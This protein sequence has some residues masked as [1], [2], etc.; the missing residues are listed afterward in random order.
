VSEPVRPATS[1]VGA[2]IG[3]VAVG[4]LAAAFGFLAAT[5]QGMATAPSRWAG[6]VPLA[7]MAAGSALAALGLA[8][9]PI[10][11][12]RSAA[13]WGA[14]AILIAFVGL[15]LLSQLLSVAGLDGG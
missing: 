14:I 4:L 13:K 7:I 9:L 8:S 3:A 2:P 6:L 12:L 15:Y 5:A 10:P 1:T 11:G